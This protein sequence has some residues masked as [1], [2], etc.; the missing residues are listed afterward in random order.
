MRNRRQSWLCI[1]AAVTGCAHGITTN[2]DTTPPVVDD[3]GAPEPVPSSPNPPAPAPPVS[4]GNACSQPGNVA[5][6]AVLGAMCDRI[7]QCCTSANGPL[8]VS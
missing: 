1:A 6:D 5:C 8:C 2:P 7:V 4:M 3:A